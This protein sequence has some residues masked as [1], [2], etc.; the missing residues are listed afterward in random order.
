MDIMI[1]RFYNGHNKPISTNFISKYIYNFV[2]M[3]NNVYIMI[4][5]I[6]RQKIILTLSLMP[7]CTLMKDQD[8]VTTQQQKEY[9]DLEV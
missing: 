2:D 1:I 5:Y 3:E 7:I 6:V 9:H 4:N 8:L